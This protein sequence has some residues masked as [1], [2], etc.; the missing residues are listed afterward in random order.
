MLC[1]TAHLNCW[2]E[3]LLAVKAFFCTAF[4]KSVVVIVV[5]IAS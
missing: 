5:V 4:S 2:P 3:L 1:I